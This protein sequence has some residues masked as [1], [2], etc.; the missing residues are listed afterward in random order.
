[1]KRIIIAWTKASLIKR[2]LI[3]MILGAT[4]GMLSKPYRNWSAWRPL[5]RRTESY[6]S[7]FGFCP[8]CQCPFPAPKGTKHQ[9]ENGHL[10]ILT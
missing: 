5:C 2:I 9:Y 10:S 1:M 8:C 3:G 4:L 7:Y 6:C